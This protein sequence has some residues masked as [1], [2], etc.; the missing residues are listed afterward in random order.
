MI[1]LFVFEEDFVKKKKRYFSFG[2]FWLT[3]H[4]VVKRCYE[5][6]YFFF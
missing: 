4:N 5:D 6:Y 2:V 3:F 1:F